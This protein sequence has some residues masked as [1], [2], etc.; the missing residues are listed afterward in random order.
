MAGIS[1]MLTSRMAEMLASSSDGIDV[2]VAAIQDGAGFF[3]AEPIREISTQNASV[4]NTERS[5]RARYPALCVYC[6]KLSNTM[7]EKFRT[8]SGKASI[9]VEVRQSQDH[10]DHI[11]SRLQ[12][13]VDAVCALLDDSRG[14][15]T[16]GAFYAGGYEVT[17]EAVGR[18]GKNFL[19]KAKV[20]FEVEVSK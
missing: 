3:E 4:E 5:G 16:G 9:V 1:G 14:D 20:K 18:G 7:R 8:F 11:E 19:Q 2:R 6:E 13:Y 15:W 12:V 10:L 17:Y